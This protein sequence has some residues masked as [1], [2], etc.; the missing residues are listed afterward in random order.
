LCGWNVL[1]ILIYP[2]FSFARIYCKAVIWTRFYR[3]VA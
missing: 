3:N 2:S 1:F